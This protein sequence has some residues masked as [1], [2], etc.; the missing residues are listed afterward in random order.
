MKQNFS[1]SSDACIQVKRV[2]QVVLLMWKWKR[3]DE[4]LPK[5]DDFNKKGKYACLYGDLKQKGHH[6]LFIYEVINTI[7]KEVV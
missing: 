2:F 6:N 3:S 5:N 1:C 7:I 4:H